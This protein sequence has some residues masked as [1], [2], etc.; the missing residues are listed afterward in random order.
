ML[1]E[2][3]PEAVQVGGAL[4]VVSDRESLSQGEGEQF[5]WLVRLIN[6]LQ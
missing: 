4:V 1:R 2:C 5:K 3:V 6:R